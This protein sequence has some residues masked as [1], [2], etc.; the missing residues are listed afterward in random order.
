MNGV[1]IM[2]VP[3]NFKIRRKADVNT[4]IE[5]CLQK[6]NRYDIVTDSGVQFIFAKDNDGNVSVL[7]RTGDLY[8]MFNPSL[9][10]ARTKDNCYKGTV[11]E[12]V[13]QNRKYI[14]AKWF[15]R[16]EN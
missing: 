7:T 10:V 13:W 11:V 14:N 2:L 15:S 1:T 8:D 12:Y 16:K 6:N 4:F 5:K 3:Q 9:E